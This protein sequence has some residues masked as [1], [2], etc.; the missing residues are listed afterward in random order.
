MYIKWRSDVEI[1]RNS[2]QLYKDSIVILYSVQ[3]LKILYGG[4]V[5]MGIIMRH[6][7]ELLKLGFAYR[8][9][10]S[11]FFLISCKKLIKFDRCNLTIYL[12][13]DPDGFLWIFVTR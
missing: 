12:S 5:A 10:N 7:L 13:Q 11:D 9:L 8:Y 1:V 2:S 4:Y 3:L 6:W